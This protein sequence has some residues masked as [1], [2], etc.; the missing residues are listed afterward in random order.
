MRFNR[1]WPFVVFILTLAF[2]MTAALAADTPQPTAPPRTMVDITEFFALYEPDP[3]RA[4]ELRALHATPEN[5]PP[6]TTNRK[7]LARFHLK[8]ADAADGIGAALFERQAANTQLS[9][10]AV[11]QHL[12]LALT[13][14]KSADANFAYAH[15]LSWAPS[16]PVGEGGN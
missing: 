15:P 7:D 10:A 5:S 12:M 9:R 11:L 4:E 14:Q 13:Q 1:V 8:K 16:A 2:G 3:K 6:Q